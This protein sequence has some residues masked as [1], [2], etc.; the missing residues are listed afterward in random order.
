MPCDDCL[1]CFFAEECMNKDVLL[2]IVNLWPNNFKIKNFEQ[3]LQKLSDMFKLSIVLLKLFNGK[4]KFDC[5]FIPN[6]SICASK[7]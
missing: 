4:L 3:L 1:N 5:K 6:Q 2:D 7:E